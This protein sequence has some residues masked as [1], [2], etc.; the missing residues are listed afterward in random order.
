VRRDGEAEGLRLQQVRTHDFHA[1]RKVSKAR[2]VLQPGSAENKN[3]SVAVD[4]V[5]GEQGVGL[6][7]GEP[8]ST[9]EVQPGPLDTLTVRESKEVPP[10]RQPG[11]DAGEVTG[12]GPA[13]VSDVV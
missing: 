2:V 10:H 11:G 5:R 1:H 12:G 4:R 9:L 7:E 8:A 13:R 6:E 3:A